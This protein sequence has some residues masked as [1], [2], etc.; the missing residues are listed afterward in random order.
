MNRIDIMID[1]ANAVDIALA[2][3][4]LDDA[5]AKVR[6][7]H[8][9]LSEFDRGAVEGIA[10]GILADGRVEEGVY[11]RDGVYFALVKAFDVHL[12]SFDGE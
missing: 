5:Q 3:T 6:D 2:G 10:A 9:A 1:A 12:M 7:R 8:N 4:G 11:T